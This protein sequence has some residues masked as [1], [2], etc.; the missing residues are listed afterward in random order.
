MKSHTGLVEEHR[1]RLAA[2]GIGVSFEAP[3]AVLFKWQIHHD[4]VYLATM[5]K[6]PLP[7]CCQIALNLRY[8]TKSPLN[9]LK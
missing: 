8:G 3:Q 4:H 6:L 9:A 7:H 1:P 5:K 2:E